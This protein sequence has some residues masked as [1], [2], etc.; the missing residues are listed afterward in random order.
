MRS[1]HIVT[2]GLLALG[3]GCHVLVDFDELPKA[4]P[5]PPL[6]TCV[7]SGASEVPEREIRLG[8][9]FVQNNGNPA[10]GELEV[11]ACPIDASAAPL[12]CATPLSATANPDAAGRV[13]L[14]ISP[15]PALDKPHLPYVRAEKE[16]LYFPTSILTWPEVRRSAE[17]PPVVAITESIVDSVVDLTDRDREADIEARG[18]LIVIVTD[19]AGD[20]ARDIEVFVDERARDGRTLAFTRGKDTV[21]DFGRSITDDDGLVVYLGLPAATELIEVPV[22]LRDTITN[23]DLFPAPIAIPIRRGE[24]T[25]VVIAPWLAT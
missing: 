25:M 11:K 16:G 24:A 10:G 14:L 21:P 23:Q 12:G 5:V 13:E 2:A 18:H 7:K 6:G 4:G 17:L 8:L 1:L 22:Q 15:G 9:T 20:P 3:G 19:C